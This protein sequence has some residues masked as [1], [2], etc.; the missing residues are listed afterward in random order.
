M[1]NNQPIRAAAMD[2]A[3]TRVAAAICTRGDHP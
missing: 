2:I 3:V 1:E